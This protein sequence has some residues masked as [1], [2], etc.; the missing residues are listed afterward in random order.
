MNTTSIILHVNNVAGIVSMRA[1]EKEIQ[2]IELTF[3]LVLLSEHYIVLHSSEPAFASDNKD[4]N[5]WLYL[6]R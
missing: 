6:L 4:C 5:I 2:E 1:S 3:L